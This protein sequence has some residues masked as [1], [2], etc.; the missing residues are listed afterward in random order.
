ML[1]GTA[2]FDNNSLD[3]KLGPDTGAVK[4]GGLRTK[5]STAPDRALYLED[6]HEQDEQPSWCGI[7]DGI[8]AR[9]DQT[10]GEKLK[11]G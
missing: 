11:R 7:G 5:F 2:V 3:A 9:R 8:F 6:H 4:A 10:G 1:R